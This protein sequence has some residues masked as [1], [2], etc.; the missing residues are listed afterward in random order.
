MSCEIW[1]VFIK[2]RIEVHDTKKGWE[3]YPKGLTLP[4]KWLKITNI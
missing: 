1:D 4:E 2:N 3:E